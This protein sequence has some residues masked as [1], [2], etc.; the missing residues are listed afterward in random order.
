MNNR[1]AQRPQAQSSAPLVVELPAV[2]P[3][4]CPSC[5]IVVTVQTLAGVPS[6]VLSHEPTCPTWAAKLRGLVP[7]AD[8][9]K[10]QTVRDLDDGDRAVINALAPRW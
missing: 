1:R 5:T 6:L 8:P 4:R 2:H 10:M 7:G 3:W 9:D